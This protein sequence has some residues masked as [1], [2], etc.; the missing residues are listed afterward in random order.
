[1]E[2][3]GNVFQEDLYAFFSLFLIDGTKE[4]FLFKKAIEKKSALKNLPC[5]TRSQNG[6]TEAEKFF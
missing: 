6:L 5:F 2:I 3:D 1:M 4:N